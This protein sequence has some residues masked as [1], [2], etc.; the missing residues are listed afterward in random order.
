M[1]VQ[2]T[3]L[4]HI[5]SVQNRVKL[6]FPKAVSY[7]PFQRG[8]GAIC[9]K[10]YG[11][12]NAFE[13]AALKLTICRIDELQSLHPQRGWGGGGGRESKTLVYKFGILYIF[14]I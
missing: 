1:E 11:T 12:K 14:L 6:C 9:T 5:S 8:R 7:G 3:K 2:G 4:N 10:L 13:N